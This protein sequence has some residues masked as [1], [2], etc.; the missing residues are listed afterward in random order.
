MKYC[1]LTKG[2]EPQKIEELEKLHDKFKNSQDD[3]W[4]ILNSFITANRQNIP[5]INQVYID[6]LLSNIRQIIYSF[7]E[8]KKAKEHFPDEKNKED[9]YYQEVE[10]AAIFVF[11]FN[12]NSFLQIVKTFT[13]YSVD[14][15]FNEL[16][17]DVKFVRHHLAH[18]YEKDTTDP[19]YTKAIVANVVQRGLEDLEMLELLALSNSMP[20]G[21][22]HFSIHVFY[23]QI[24]KIFEVLANDPRQ[25]T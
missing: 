11:I 4:D 2:Y 5:L 7:S 21:N 13:K 1:I 17:R 24:K 6:N 22:L 9:N 23:F 19:T 15:D 25:F 8:L 12:A 18:S 10:T 20:L 14:K 16:L 3:F